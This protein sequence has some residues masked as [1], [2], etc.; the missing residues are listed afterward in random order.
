MEKLYEYLKGDEWVVIITV[1]ISLYVAIV[2]FFMTHVRGKRH[3]RRSKQENAYDLIK[4]LPQT[5][6]CPAQTAL[7]SRHHKYSALSGKAYV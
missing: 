2:S 6:S 4:L 3:Y 7:F 1:I 5:C